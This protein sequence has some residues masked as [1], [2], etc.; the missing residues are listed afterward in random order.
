MTWSA[1]TLHHPGVGGQGHLALEA[2]GHCKV[3]GRVREPAGHPS[4]DLAAP[5]WREVAARAD[6]GCAHLQIDDASFAHRCDDR[7]RARFREWGEDPDDIQAGITD[8]GGAGRFLPVSGSGPFED[9][10]QATVPG[11]SHLETFR[12]QAGVHPSGAIPSM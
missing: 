12:I 1:L 7:R 6:A 11:S 4:N 5:Y 8:T 9:G 10:A 3:P 2:N